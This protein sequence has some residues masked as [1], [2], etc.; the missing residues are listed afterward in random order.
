MNGGLDLEERLNN[1][2]EAG[3]GCRRVS[4]VLGWCRE[5]GR[6]GRRENL[7]VDCV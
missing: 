3:C 2:F 4:A 6:R 5:L 7:T 1:I